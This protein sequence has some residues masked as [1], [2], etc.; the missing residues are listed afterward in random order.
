MVKRALAVMALIGL[1]ACSGEQTGPSSPADADGCSGEMMSTIRIDKGW[2]RNAPAG[3]AVSAGYMTLCNTADEDDRLLAATSTIA[4]STEIHEM[5]RGDAGQM[6]M[7]P[8]KSGLLLQPGKTVR[9]EPG[10]LHLMFIDLNAPLVP[11]ETVALALTF[12]R[13]GTIDLTLPVRDGMTGPHR[14]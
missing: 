14:E 7:R 6:Q 12:E 13:A 11:G 3:R 8:L 10:G 1:A 2:I 5:R 9:L 4:K